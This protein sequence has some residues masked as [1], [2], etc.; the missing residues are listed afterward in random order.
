MRT[1]SRRL[2]RLEDRACLQRDETGETPA[3]VF[4][5][6]IPRLYEAEGVPFEDPPPE[7]FTDDRGRLL[8][9]ADIL[10][11]PQRL[12]LEARL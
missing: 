3:E 6:R 9:V 1:M 2:Q 5:V 12:G 4:R 8:S 7:E 10:R 11:R